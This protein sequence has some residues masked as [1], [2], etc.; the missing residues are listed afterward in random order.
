MLVGMATESVHRRPPWGVKRAVGFEVSRGFFR[1]RSALYE[2]L[3]F[4][5][6]GAGNE[7]AC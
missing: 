5:F 3:R 6:G 2:V 7:K 4:C 1:P